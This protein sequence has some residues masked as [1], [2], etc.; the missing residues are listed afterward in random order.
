MPP[1]PPATDRC[2]GLC[3]TPRRS[4]GTARR[5]G[6]PVQRVGPRSWGHHPSPSPHCPIGSGG[7]TVCR[8]GSVN[9]GVR[10]SSGK[11]SRLH[12]K[13]Q[14]S[15]RVVAAIQSKT[16]SLPKGNQGGVWGVFGSCGL[17][18]VWYCVQREGAGCPGWQRRQPEDQWARGSG[19][20]SRA[21]RMRGASPVLQ[22]KP[23]IGGNNRWFGPTQRFRWSQI[24]AN[25]RG[26]GGVA[27]GFSR[28]G[29][30]RP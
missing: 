11:L 10:R 13:P 19:K 9:G 8:W 18:S 22:K 1:F 20:F 26:G 25:S 28:G 7:T 29:M 24:G 30:P 4:T 17:S 12:F 23:D 15:G 5:P 14:I 6:A 3:A 2:D 16:L 27:L 21:M